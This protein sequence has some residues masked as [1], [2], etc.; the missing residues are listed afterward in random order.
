MELGRGSGRVGGCGNGEN[1]YGP[2]SS[3]WIV[4]GVGETEVRGLQRNGRVFEDREVFIGAAGSVVDRRHI[5]GHG[6]GGWIIFD[7]T[8]GGA[9]EVLHSK[10]EAGV[11]V[12]VS[13]RSWHVSHATA[14]DGPE[15]VIELG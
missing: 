4:V 8:I 1:M 7:T 5:E 9:A 2:E 15:R 12:S 14:K 13:I 3:G 11:V 10:G 6:V